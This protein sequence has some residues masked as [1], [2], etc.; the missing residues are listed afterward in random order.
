M[1][2]NMPIASLTLART[3]CHRSQG[4]ESTHEPP[5]A[6]SQAGSRG[7]HPPPLF[8]VG[9]FETRVS[10]VSFAMVKMN[11]KLK[12]QNEESGFYFLFSIFHFAFIFAPVASR[13]P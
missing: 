2:D 6:P 4:R 10:I 13:L 11:E 7:P 9:Q 12:I 5:G 1:R 3:P 8:L